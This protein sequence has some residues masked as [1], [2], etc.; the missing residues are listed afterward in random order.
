MCIFVG[1]ESLA[2]CRSVLEKGEY[3]SAKLQSIQ[4]MRVKLKSVIVFSKR[5]LKVKAL[6]LMSL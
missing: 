2:H 1:F 3:L 5:K 6:T 4:L